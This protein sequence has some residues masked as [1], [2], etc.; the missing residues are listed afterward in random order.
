MDDMTPSYDPI[1]WNEEE[2]YEPEHHMPK[3]WYRMYETECVLCWRGG[4]WRER[5]YGQRPTDRAD[6]YVFEQYLCDDHYV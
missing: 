4:K 6:R 3:H 5:V 1:D 2:G